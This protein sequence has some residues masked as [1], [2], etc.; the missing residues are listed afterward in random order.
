VN[1]VRDLV[2]DLRA[3]GV[4]L[5]PAPGVYWLTTR[6]HLDPAVRRQAP[7]DVIDALEDLHRVLGGDRRVLAHRRDEIIRTDLLVTTSGQLVQVDGVAHFTSDRLASLAHYP[8]T[9]TLGFSVDHYRS[10]IETWRDRAASV[11]TRRWSPDFDFAGGRRARRAYEDA[12]VDLLAP[13][14]TGFPVLRIAA[15]EGD[16]SHVADALVAGLA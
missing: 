8:A 11:F 1:L 10:L 7:A 14:F 12:L 4:A 2:A 13:V 9:A 16:A 15:P 3:R 5:A 6:G